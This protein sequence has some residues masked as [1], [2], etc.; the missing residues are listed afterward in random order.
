MTDEKQ[1]LQLTPDQFDS[2]VKKGHIYINEVKYEMKDVYLS[3]E[4]VKKLCEKL[5]IKF[6]LEDKND[7]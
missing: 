2:I 1:I 6:P 4:D 7:K 5:N 3:E